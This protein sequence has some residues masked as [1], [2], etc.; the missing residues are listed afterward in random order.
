MTDHDNEPRS[1]DEGANR[2]MNFIQPAFEVGPPGVGPVMGIDGGEFFQP[3]TPDDD[4]AEPAAD[5]Q[6]EA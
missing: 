4:A 2:A 5:P 3:V 1:V 6:A